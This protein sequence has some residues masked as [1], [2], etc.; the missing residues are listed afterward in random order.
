MILPPCNIYYHR[1]RYLPKYTFAFLKIY[2]NNSNS[3][4]VLDDSDGDLKRQMRK[5][6]ANANMLLQKFSYCSPSVKC[7]LCMLFNYCINMGFESDNKGFIYYSI[8]TD[9]HNIHSSNVALPLCA[10]M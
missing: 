1:Q 3:I 8:A 5:Y 10:A 4:T 9:N 2:Y 6:Y 7:C